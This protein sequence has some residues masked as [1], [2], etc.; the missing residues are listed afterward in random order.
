M[1]TV[2]IIL[3]IFSSSVCF[4]EL[5]KW[6]DDKGALHF[7]DDITAIPEK[8]RENVKTETM[9]EESPPKKYQKIEPGNSSFTDDAAKAAQ[10]QKRRERANYF[11][12]EATRLKRNIERAQAEYKAYSMNQYA[13][14][15]MLQSYYNDIVSAQKA[16]DDF[17]EQARKNAIPPGWLRCQFE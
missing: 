15:S 1:K 5:Y 7:T 14:R 2:L 16:F 6:V 11:F 9:K 3:I 4:A 12:T 13:T 8:Y 10:E 17:E